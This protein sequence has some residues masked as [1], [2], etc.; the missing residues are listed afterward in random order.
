MDS[1]WIQGKI[2]EYSFLELAKILLPSTEFSTFSY[3]CVQVAMLPDMEKI[4]KN[5]IPR[6]HYVTK[7]EE[8]AIFNR[9]WNAEKNYEN[10]EMLYGFYFVDVPLGQLARNFPDWFKDK[11]IDE[12]IKPY[13]TEEDGSICFSKKIL[14]TAVFCIL[15][16]YGHYLDYKRLGKEQAVLW[17]CEA[18][19]PFIEIDSKFKQMN[20]QGTVTKELYE[21]RKIVY[22]NCEDEHSA[23]MYA[24][25]H[26][27]EKVIEAFEY[28]NREA[29]DE[30]IS[31]NVE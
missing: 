31:R 20:K 7:E 11:A 23:D 19:K 25:S 10:S 8:Q 12:L 14:T 6:F 24:L 15:H 1:R 18:K 29:A 17:A 2:E 30:A 26:L 21:K 27:R 5:M 3:P 16:E 4:R 22:R 13:Y 9:N 28:I